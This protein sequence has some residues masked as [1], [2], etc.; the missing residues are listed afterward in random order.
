[1]RLIVFVGLVPECSRIL[2]AQERLSVEIMGLASALIHKKLAQMQVPLLTRHPIQFHQRELDFFM[3]GVTAFLARFSAEDGIDV[4]RIATQRIQ[5]NALAGG[6]EMRHRCFDEVTGTIQLMPVTQVRP[7]LLR[8]DNGEIGIE[9]AIGL[10]GGDNKADNFVNLCLQRRVWMGGK[11]V[12]RGFKPLGNIRV[13]E[14]VWNR[15]HSWFPTQPQGVDTSLLLAEPVPMRQGVFSVYA[16][17][18]RPKR[19]V[20]GNRLPGDWRPRWTKLIR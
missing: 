5:Q 16:N 13:P 10:L 14:D 15:L 8:L 4:V 20:D 12:A 17:M 7:A 1:M 3:S 18:R 11:T 6:R 2:A 19:V 9:I